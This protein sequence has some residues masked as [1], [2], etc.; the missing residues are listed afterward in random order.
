VVWQSM[1]TK[2]SSLHLNNFLSWKEGSISLHPQ[3]TLVV[4][5]GNVG[6]TSLV[7]ALLWGLRGDSSNPEP[8]ILGSPTCV[9]VELDNGKV[10]ERTKGE[11]VNE[12][13][14]GD[15]K[16]ERFGLHLPD[17]VRDYTEVSPDSFAQQHDPPFLLGSGPTAVYQK[18]SAPFGGDILLD[19]AATVRSEKEMLVR[20]MR[21]L[22]EDKKVYE[23]RVLVLGEVSLIRSTVNSANDISNKIL[24]EEG[25]VQLITDLSK[26]DFLLSSFTQAQEDLESRLSD[27]TDRARRLRKVDTVLMSLVEVYEDMSKCESDMESSSRSI[28][29]M[30][31]QISQ[32]KVCPLCGRRI[33]NAHDLCNR[34]TLVQ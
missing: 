17:E 15:R 8:S 30:S 33:E 27:I 20:R 2:I 12:V 9:R 25:I 3:I 10:I 14:F 13:T 28:R 19:A 32:I 22:E 24:E 29:E 26:V 34:F 21:Q 11:D 16:F 1:G 18:L 7:R 5:S 6:K 31:L 23:D 4:G